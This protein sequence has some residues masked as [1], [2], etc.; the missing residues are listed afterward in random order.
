MWSLHCPSL[1]HSTHRSS[2][3]GVCTVV[4]DRSA[5]I[6]ADFAPPT[7][8]FPSP[9]RAKVR[10]PRKR[11]SHRSPASSVS[12]ASMPL[13]SPKLLPFILQGS[14]S[15]GSCLPLTIPRYSAF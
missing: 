9:E 15:E 11:A 14:I 6:V 8:P 13:K 10:K 7:C 1:T 4:S 5:T 12:Q 2:P 3:S